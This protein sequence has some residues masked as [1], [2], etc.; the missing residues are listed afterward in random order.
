MDEY[1]SNHSP[2]FKVDETALK[3]GVRT[4]AQETID[5]MAGQSQ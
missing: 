1:A 4:L 2:R 3:L 5:Y